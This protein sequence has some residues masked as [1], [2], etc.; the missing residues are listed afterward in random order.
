MSTKAQV[1]AEFLFILAA[2]LII[3]VIIAILAQQQMNTLQKQ[4]D[5]QDTQNSL[6]DLSTAAK[7][8]YAQGEGSKM[9]VFVQL[10]GS[11]EPNGSSVGNKSIQ[12]R[13]SGTDYV[14]LENF[15]VRGNLPGASGAHWVWV[16]S[17][18]NL[19]RIGTAL[20]GL[21]R[22][23]IS[24]VLAPGESTSVSLYA[25]NLW[26][27]NLSVN[28]ELKWSNPA[29]SVSDSVDDF[30]L[31]PGDTYPLSIDF[32][33]SSNAS[34]YY[35]GE[36][37]FNATDGNV[38][39]TVNLPIAVEVLVSVSDQA[40]PLNVTPDFWAATLQ[41]TNTSS[42]TFSVCTNSYTSLSSVTFT[43]SAGASGSWV[44]NTGAL[45]PMATGSCQLKTMSLT[46]PNGTA[47]GTYSGSIE[48]VGQGAV[49]ARDT[50][51]LFITVP[52]N[53]SGSCEP[54]LSNLTLCNCPVGSL[55]W[56]IPVC[57]CQPATIYVLNGT[58]IGGPDDGKPYNGTING[59]PGIDVIAGMFDESDIIYGGESG[60]L[61]CGH[62]G[63]DIIYGG[64]GDDILDGGLGNDTIYGESGYD[65]IYGKEDNDWISGGQG[66]D[67]IDGGDGD[68]ILY[69]DDQDDLMYGGPGDDIIIGGNGKETICGNANND[70]IDAGEGN[71]I[72]DGGTGVNTING[73]GG[74]NDCYR[75]P[76]MTNCTAKSGTYPACG[77]S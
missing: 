17:E 1:S 24:L 28:T 22:N 68:D 62:G 26:T 41:P 73:G 21:S 71:D 45:G 53:E 60:D 33:P 55:Y 36:L 12:I 58:I 38:S 75:G 72:I 2:L 31:S 14:A 74:N 51:S 43:P 69:G 46:V 25:E 4:K 57:M 29:V 34:G 8:V 63:D 13:A 32:Q 40:P 23:S 66:N 47:T 44:T 27:N 67:Q 5:A 54:G 37:V 76:N 50:I 64:N 19:V 77:P 42:M 59:G 6:L 30:Y 52:N 65:K 3:I 70:N 15:N 16:V 9:L 11:Y 10:P 49:G 39:E 61:I 18:G 7:E 48:V 56:D 20:L 35:S